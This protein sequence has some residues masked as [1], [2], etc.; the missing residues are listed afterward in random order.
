LL[1]VSLAFSSMGVN[2]SKCAHKCALVVFPIPGDPEIMTA[3]KVFMP[4]LPGFLKP[5]F[6]FAGLYRDKDEQHG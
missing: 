1:L 3:R 2:P 5:H 4:C 6:K